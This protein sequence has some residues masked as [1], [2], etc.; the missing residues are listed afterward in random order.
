MYLYSIAYRPYYFSP[1]TLICEKYYCFSAAN[2]HISSRCNSEMT[3]QDRRGIAYRRRACYNCVLPSSHPKGHTVK[4]CTNSNRC[5]TTL[6]D[7]TTCNAKHHTL[8]CYKGTKSG[9]KEE[10]ISLPTTSQVDGK[11]DQY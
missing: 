9:P 5:R 8:L 2:P 3:V 7:G 11:E 1:A 4:D 10:G 6:P